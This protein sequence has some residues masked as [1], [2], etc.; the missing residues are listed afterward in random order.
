LIKRE[1][2]YIDV[3]K[4]EYNILKFAGSL[5]GFKH[6]IDSIERTRIV[7]IGRKHD[8]ATK[9]KLSAN[10]QTHPIT[11]INNKTGEVKLFTSIRQTAKFIGIHHSYL[12]K[13]LA[14]KKFYK[15]KG[16]YITKNLCNKNSDFS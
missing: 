14:K 8:E 6:S 10:S 2:Y 9:L 7:N 4:P 5:S 12:A 1:Q 13:C 3:L 15:G 16:Y 11:A